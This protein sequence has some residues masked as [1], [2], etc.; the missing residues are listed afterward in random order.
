MKARTIYQP[1]ASLLAYGAKVYETTSRYI[2]YRGPIAI[3]AGLRHI[4]SLP[5]GAEQEAFCALAERIPFFNGLA[6]LPRGCVLATG[7]LIG[8]YRI[9]FANVAAHEV[10]YD[11]PKCEVANTLGVSK[12][13]LL[14]GD[15]RGGR[16]FLVF[17]DIVPLPKPIPA[18]GQQGLWNW[19]M[20]T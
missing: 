3:H 13:E 1:Y 17:A 9:L 16:Y 19:E 20:P 7:Q 8:C 18:K 12:N 5:G 4:S 2:G 15:W 10:Y 14:F 11:N 6:H